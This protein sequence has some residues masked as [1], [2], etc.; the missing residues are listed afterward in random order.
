[1]LSRGVFVERGAVIAGCALA[2]LLGL[3]LGL[4]PMTPR[5]VAGLAGL[6]LLMAGTGALA[7]LFA[8][9]H[10]VTSGIGWGGLE[11]TS[12]LIKQAA[13]ELV[14]GHADSRLMETV[15]RNANGQEGRAN[16]LYMHVRL[17]QLREAGAYQQK[18]QPN[19]V[20]AW[21]R[22]VW[23]AVLL[24]SSLCAFASTLAPQ[25]GLPSWTP[26]VVIA[27]L[28]PLWLQAFAVT[29]LGS[30]RR[31]SLPK[32]RRKDADQDLKV[33]LRHRQFKTAAGSWHTRP[34]GP[35]V[36][37]LKFLMVGILLIAVLLY[38]LREYGPDM[39][40]LDPRYRPQE[41][42][43]EIVTTPP[44][45]VTQATPKPTA[46]VTPRRAAPPPQ[47]PTASTGVL[48][49]RVPP[50]G[51]ALQVSAR[52]MEFAGWDLRYVEAVFAEHK[53]RL[54]EWYTRYEHRHPGTAGRISFQM[55]LQ[56]YGGV[57]DIR[58]VDSEMGAQELINGL[59]D[60]LEAIDFGRT[61]L[62]PVPIVL[63]MDFRP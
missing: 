51:V 25:F 6:M 36:P 46:Q 35:D 63:A 45:E 7:G 61:A 24:S 11:E 33:D 13:A 34:S 22:S 55:V 47:P 30:T 41:I 38:A 60:R 49:A 31:L 17:A 12:A 4:D 5:H 19:P 8:Y 28:A 20:P 26:L 44:P 3:A 48:W 16:A 18:A 29:G 59:R 23:S 27:V 43:P 10:T 58:L 39:L 40:G 52:A 1:M 32:F 56:P 42:E 21:R 2:P 53:S 37:V 15:A 14:T 57:S 9:R 54:D 50:R 62:D